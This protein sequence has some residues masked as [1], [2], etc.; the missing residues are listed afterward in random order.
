MKTI[1]GGFIHVLSYPSFAIKDIYRI[2][3]YEGEAI[4]SLLRLYAIDRD[5]TW[6]NEVKS[7]FDYFITND[8]WRHHDHRLSY[9]ANELTIYAPEDRYFIF[10]LKN[11]QGRL[12]FI[13]HCV[14]T[15]PTFLELTMA[16]YKMID[17]LNV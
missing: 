3:Y 7:S 9:S 14:T 6:L 4:F 17:R 8:Y 10:G 12:D 13:Y 5:E 2:I 1:S 11:C 15:Y 16:A